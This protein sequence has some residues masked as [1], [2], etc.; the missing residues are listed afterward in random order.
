MPNGYVQNH[1][2]VPVWRDAVRAGILPTARGVTLTAEDRLRRA[3]IERIMCDFAVDLRDVAACFAVDPT[4]LMDAA[5]SLQVM[6]R[7]G[8]LDWDGYALRLKPAGR[9]FVR[10]VAAAFDARA[11]SSAARHSAA[12]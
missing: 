2:A 3:V 5:P 12:V 11:R 7:D 4:I 8:L 1:A 10:T 9:P 6:A